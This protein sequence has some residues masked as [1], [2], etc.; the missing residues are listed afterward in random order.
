VIL[1]FLSI[2]MSESTQQQ[3]STNGGPSSTS[4]GVRTSASPEE[5][6][7][8]ALE[9]MTRMRT[10]QDASQG[11]L[12]PPSLF[13]DFREALNNQAVRGA[14][15]DRLNGIFTSDS[16][17]EREDEAQRTVT[18]YLASLQ[19]SSRVI[20]PNLGTNPHSQTMRTLAHKDWAE[21]LEQVITAFQHVSGHTPILEQGESSSAGTVT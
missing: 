11:P 16:A 20:R 2:Q 1:R 5:I 3:Q 14:V 18:E 4:S 13:R 12:R 21:E 6:R 10:Q 17:R 9:Y 15:I 8:S 19:A 7:S